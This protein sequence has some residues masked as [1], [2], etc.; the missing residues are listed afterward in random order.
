MLLQ[1]L[2]A[3]DHGVVR[4]GLRTLLESTR[5][6]KVCA[7]ATNG[8]RAVE[9]VR[10]CKPDVAILDIS[11]PE[12]NGVEATRQIRQLYP[13]TEVLIL[14]MHESDVLLHESLKAGAKGYL[15]KEDADDYLLSAVDALRQHKQ[16]FSPKIAKA[17]AGETFPPLPQASQR[18]V[19]LNRLTGRER[20]VIQLLAEGKS[21]KEVATTLG[22]S[23]K[24][25][26]AHRTRIMLKLG[27][28]SIT[29]L[30]R[31]AIRNTI[32]VS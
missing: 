4:K 16:Y 21:N 7:E 23:V 2:I 27:V 15:L 31:Y 11:M 9:E 18:N 14:S 17:M 25:V 32:I 20:E 5:G 22:I 30:V 3:D 24:T 29:G 10:A 8:R 1:I 12:L 28:H 13:Q 19:P 26:E 6:W